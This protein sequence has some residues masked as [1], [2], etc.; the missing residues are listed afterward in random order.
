MRTRFLSGYRVSTVSTVATVAAFALALLCAAGCDTQP[1]PTSAAS[2]DG[3]AAGQRYDNVVDAVVRPMLE[4]HG[5][6]YLPE[7]D[8]ILCRSD[9][10]DHPLLEEP[11]K[12]VTIAARSFDWPAAA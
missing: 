7:Q 8:A 3:G 5:L 10:N 2:D 9:Q 4:S 11:G 1:A 6:K 12:A